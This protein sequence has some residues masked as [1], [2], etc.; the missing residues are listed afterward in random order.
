MNFPQ[1]HEAVKDAENTL[2]LADTIAERIA[3]MLIGRLRKV[4]S[5]LC[6]KNAQKGV[7]RFQHENRRMEE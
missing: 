5:I 2:N 3:K 1:L 6:A 4:N 7:K